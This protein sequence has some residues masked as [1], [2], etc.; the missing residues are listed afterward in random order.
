MTDARV[1][2]G[3]VRRVNGPLVEVTGLADLAMSDLVELGAAGLP[4]EVVAV[5]HHGRVRAGLRVHRRPR[6]GDP[7]TPLGRPLS[8]RLG[9]WLLGGVFDGL[10]R[11]L[12]W[13]P[14]GWSP[15]R[16]ARR[17]PARCRRRVALAAGRRGGRRGRTR[18]GPR[19]RAGRGQRGLPG[20]GASGCA[21]PGRQDRAGRAA[22]GRPAGGRGRRHAGRDRHAAGRYAG[23]GRCGAGCRH[24]SPCSPGSASSTCCSRWRGAARAAVPG[25]FGTGKTVLLQQIAK[26]CDADVIVYVGC[27]E[28]GNEMADVL[29]ELARARR[30]AH[31]RSPRGAHRDHRQHL[32]HADDGARG[33]H[34][35]RR[36]GRRV[37]PRHGLRRRRHRRLH[38]ALGRGAA[39]VRLA[40]RRAAGRGGL[41]GRPRLGARRLLR[42]GRARTSP[43]GEPRARSPSS[44]RSRR[45]AAT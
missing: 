25:G 22:P 26:W 14:P 10:L 41:P 7:V 8:A 27:G 12:T 24:R 38:L 3:R 13:R 32:E 28:R 29:D 4:G 42:A 18:R 16:S 6:R 36:H 34:L 33:Q 2:G 31:R 20:A 1:T 35:H 19:H 11:P 37:L 17:R 39:R 43:S 15:R 45:R 9:P 21:R 40:H 5:R 30:P 44:A 23:R